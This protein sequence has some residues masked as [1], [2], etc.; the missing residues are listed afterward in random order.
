M[1]AV[2]L[3]I[4]TIVIGIGLKEISDTLKEIKEK[5]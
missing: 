1:T 5:L 4:A 2:V 3:S